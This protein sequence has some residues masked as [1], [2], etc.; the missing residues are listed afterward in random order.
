MKRTVAALA[1]LLSALLLLAAFK[2]AAAWGSQYAPE[3]GSF[4]PSPGD[5]ALRLNLLLLVLPAGVLLAWAAA[6]LAGE[7]VATRFDEVGT[8]GRSWELLLAVWVLLATWALRRYVLL[9]TEVTD[10]ENAYEL[11]ARLIASGRLFVPSL[12]APFRQFLDNQAVVNDG[13]RYGVY[14]IGHPAVLA[15]FRRLA[16]ES[17][18]GPVAAALT[19]WLAVATARRVF[20][21]RAAA[22]AGALLATSPFFLLLSATHLSQPTSSLFLALFTYALV[23]IDDAPGR[24]RWWALAAAAVSAAVLTRPQTG[25]AFFLV[26]LIPL[27][28]ALVRGRVRPG[29]LPIAAGGVTGLVGL[30]VFLWV[31]AVRSGH[32]LRSGYAAYLQAGNPYLLPVGLAYSLRQAQE[33]LG[34]L[35]FWLFGWPMSLAFL[36]F[37]ERNRAGVRL[38]AT[39]AAVVLIYAATAVPTVAPVGPVYFGECIPILAMLTGS[40]IDRAVAWLRARAAPTAAA[41][42]AALPAVLTALGLVT[43]VPPQVVGLATSAAI[44]RL[45]YDLAKRR[46]LDHAVVFASALPGTVLPPKTWA[47]FH[48]NADPD[49]ADPVLFVRDLGP[50]RDREF[51]RFLGDR[52]GWVLGYDGRRF[53]LKSLA[54]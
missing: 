36:P 43:F 3:Y 39:V 1:S 22:L 49:L 26:G 16:I 41:A 8:S 4:P 53:E 35:V 24:A 48:R 10:D 47:Y 28:V 6:L 2:G 20:G 52:S 45:P 15:A 21:G 51:L 11:Q 38:A 14:F 29:P 19:A 44:T 31:N 27:G 37:F 32:P 5:L 18:A 17:W 34:H 9:G 33:A 25:V 46:G 23:R 54:P 12:P 40:G 7:R 30:G 42:T 50:D 13:K